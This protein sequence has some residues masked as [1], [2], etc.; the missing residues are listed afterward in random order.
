MVG[1][2]QIENAYNME[3]AGNCKIKK[4]FVIAQLKEQ[5]SNVIRIVIGTEYGKI[6]YN[7][8][9]VFRNRKVFFLVKTRSSH[10]SVRPVVVSSLEGAWSNCLDLS[11]SHKTAAVHSLSMLS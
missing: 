8:I 6:I 3:M 7:K 2:K 10:P 11:H 5:V 9:C 1:I 4:A